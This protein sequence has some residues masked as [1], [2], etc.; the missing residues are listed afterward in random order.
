MKPDLFVIFG[1]SPYP[2]DVAMDRLLDV[3]E[4]GGGALGRWYA[5]VQRDAYGQGD[6]DFSVIHEVSDLA[7]RDDLRTRIRRNGSGQADYWSRRMGSGDEYAMVFEDPSPALSE[8]LD[9]TERALLRALDGRD[10]GAAA[11]YADWLEAAGALG[12]AEMVRL[13]EELMAR[14]PGDARAPRLRALARAA[15]PVWRA[16]VHACTTTVLHLAASTSDPWS[17]GAARF[18]AYDPEHDEFRRETLAGFEAMAVAIE[19][20]HFVAGEDLYDWRLLDAARFLA[21]RALDHGPV[22]DHAR[23]W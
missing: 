16:R 23:R 18:V 6:G 4:A 12:R 14:A 7:G 13:R 8:E 17:S 21:S 20:T 9:A 10:P 5:E 1:P 11:V 19:A 15:D 3:I 2:P 22:F